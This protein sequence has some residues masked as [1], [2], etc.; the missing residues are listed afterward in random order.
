M[1]YRLRFTPEVSKQVQKLDPESARRIRKF[2]ERIN[3]GD[4]CSTGTPLTGAG[5]FWRYRVGD[6]RIIARISDSELLIL[7]IS[8]DHRR[9]IYRNVR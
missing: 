1:T 5:H 6:Y 7:V 9:Q 2:L 8:V 3:L 4:P